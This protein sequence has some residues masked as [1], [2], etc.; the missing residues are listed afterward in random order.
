VKD[1]YNYTNYG[2][3]KSRYGYVTKGDYQNVYTGY[4]SYT[5]GHQKIEYVVESHTIQVQSYGGYGHSGYNNKDRMMVTTKSR[6]IK[7][8]PVHYFLLNESRGKLV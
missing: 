1:D 6:F 4:D 2:Q 8:N 7:K 5:D 3:C